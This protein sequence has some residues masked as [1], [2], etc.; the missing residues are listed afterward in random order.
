MQAQVSISS[1][2]VA[3]K[4]RS[5]ESATQFFRHFANG[6]TPVATSTDGQP[7]CLLALRVQ[8]V[9]PAAFALVPWLRSTLNREYV[10]PRERHEL[11]LMDR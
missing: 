6:I 7:T 2:L 1:A 4:Q 10:R 5:A 3:S 11:S 8:S 9:A